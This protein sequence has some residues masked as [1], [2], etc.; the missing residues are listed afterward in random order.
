V[1]PPIGFQAKDTVPVFTVP[2]GYINVAAVVD[3][4]AAVLPDKSD[5]SFFA[6]LSREE[7][8]SPSGSART[9]YAARAMLLEL[10]SFCHGTVSGT[11]LVFS[12]KSLLCS[13]QV[14]LIHE[15][16]H[17]KHNRFILAA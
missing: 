2:E 3:A 14:R 8:L 17:S 9:E 12:V 11:M 15:Q 16:R 13:A 7:A 6:L 1:L 4:S 10:L 5:W